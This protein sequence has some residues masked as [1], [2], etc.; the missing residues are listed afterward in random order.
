M[1]KLVLMLLLLALVAGCGGSGDLSAPQGAVILLTPSSKDKN[2]EITST[3]TVQKSVVQLYQIA[4]KDSDLAGAKGV[5]DTIFN[6]T[7]EL[8][9][10]PGTIT[11]DFTSLVT[12]CDGSR[13]I[14]T[15]AERQ[16]D[17]QGIYN[18]CVVFTTG[19]GLNYTGN[20]RV[21]S[22]ASSAST[23]IDVKSGTQTFAVSPTSLDVKA[24]SRGQFTITGGSPEYTVTSSNPAILP[25]PSVVTSSGGAF[26]VNVPAGT[27][28]GS[29]I[30][31]TI[32]DATNSTVTSTI[33]VSDPQPPVVL[34]ATPT[35]VAGGTVTFTIIGG[36][37]N[38]TVFSGNTAIIPVPD[39]V[40]ANGGT[41][42]VTIPVTTAGG[43]TIALTVRDSIG[44]TA[45]ATITV[46]APS[47]P[48]I[49]PSSLSIVAGNVGTFAITGGVPGYTVV[50]NNATVSPSPSH[51]AA[52]GDTFRVVT[53]STMSA[54]SAVITVIDSIGQA[55]SATI[56]ITAAPLSL[57]I[58]PPSI[59]VSSD[60]ERSLSF[61]VSGGTAPYSITSS[62]ANDVYFGAQGNG[63][64]TGS[65]FTATVRQ[66]AEAGTVT[67][68]VFDAAGASAASTVTIQ[69]QPLIAPGS[70]TVLSTVGGTVPFTISHGT[71]P[72]S[73]TSSNAAQLY[74]SA[75]GTGSLSNVT[76]TFTG[77]VP[78]GAAIGVVT[79]TVTGADGISNTA[80][81][82]IQ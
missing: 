50:S 41:F 81:V 54:T 6:I 3:S 23:T 2:I 71:A 4:V 31:F 61:S 49:T 73:V 52:S 28:T 44:G 51:V 13:I 62:K 79:V 58:T 16:T 1:K 26:L 57:S 25:V 11:T 35:V 12:L 20:L 19:G 32:K 14:N 17:N 36:V 10:V 30:T 8:T 82:T 39:T 55:V 68:R 77:T 64:T 59:V 60:I 67:I 47:K 43:T 80:T 69:A 65:S 22:G 34:P 45:T 76:S 70:A 42:S 46:Q 33:T 24:G 21:L 56:T 29:V 78:V 63:T 66:N 53:S 48:V 40:I 15:T 5:R 27:P 38:Y 7:F 9:N 75:P 72:Y 37:P 74:F 18:L